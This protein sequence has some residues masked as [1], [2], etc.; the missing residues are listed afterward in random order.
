MHVL[1]HCSDAIEENQGRWNAVTQ[2]RKD[3]G[4][5]A[6]I[7]P[8]VF[9]TNSCFVLLKEQLEREREPDRT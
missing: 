2:M 4:K 3:L 8:K 7:R 1:I 5:T 6:K 9:T